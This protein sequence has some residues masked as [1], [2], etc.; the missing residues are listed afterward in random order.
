MSRTR[1]IIAGGLAFVVEA[2]IINGYFGASH[3]A[4]TKVLTRRLRDSYTEKTSE[5]WIEWKHSHPAARPDDLQKALMR[6][7]NAV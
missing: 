3:W 5:E 7:R 4:P 1:L 6:E 2:I